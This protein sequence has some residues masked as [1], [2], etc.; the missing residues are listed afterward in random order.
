MEQEQ[1]NANLFQQHPDNE[2]ATAMPI[3]TEDTLSTEVAEVSDHSH[4][5]DEDVPSEVDETGDTAA[6]VEDDVPEPT[7]SEQQEANKN[8]SIEDTVYNEVPEPSQFNESQKM[9][10]QGLGLYELIESL[11]KNVEIIETNL[12]TTQDKCN[13]LNASAEALQQEVTRLKDKLKMVEEEEQSKL[14]EVKDAASNQ[15]N[16]V[17]DLRKLVTEKFNQLY[18]VATT[19]VD[20]AN[21]PSRYQSQRVTVANAANEIITMLR[22]IQQNINDGI[23]KQEGEAS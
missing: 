5:Y 6:V 19:I 1:H 22:F 7:E 8:V 11:Q 21:D 4:L 9:V 15:I 14:Q 23:F 20:I 10:L 12:V 18:P 2:S 3:G 16:K 17:N 13:M